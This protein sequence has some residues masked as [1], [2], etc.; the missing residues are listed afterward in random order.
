MTLLAGL[1]PEL[2]RD[3]PFVLPIVSV[4]MIGAIALVCFIVYF[5]NK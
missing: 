1:M 4:L 3:R 5:R 2:L